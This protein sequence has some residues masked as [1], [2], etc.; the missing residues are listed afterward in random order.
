MYY[1]S[2]SS[3]LAPKNREHAQ[4]RDGQTAISQI[5]NTQQLTT[6]S[7]TNSTGNH[8][9]FSNAPIVSHNVQE[10]KNRCIIKA[11]LTFNNYSSAMRELQT[12]VIIEFYL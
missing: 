1:Y 8:N 10:L 2:C 5:R 12:L 7:Q 9:S 3:Q 11:Y 4:A 6:H